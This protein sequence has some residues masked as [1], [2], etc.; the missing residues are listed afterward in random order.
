MLATSHGEI[1]S[2][3]QR[4]NS[5]P[6]AT[7]H[8][9]LGGK[10]ERERRLCSGGGVDTCEGRHKLGSSDQRRFSLGPLFTS[11][12]KLEPVDEVLV[13][14]SNEVWSL[15]CLDSKPH[16]LVAEVTSSQRGI[17]LANSGILSSGS[18]FRCLG[19]LILQRLPP[20]QVN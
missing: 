10:R 15:T 6:K 16:I 17:V 19:N 4:L 5:F 13:L 3:A 7:E 18:S 2:A 8:R 12:D 14:R 1:T 9:S 11:L 20:S